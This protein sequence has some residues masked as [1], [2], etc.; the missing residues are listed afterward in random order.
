MVTK[1]AR[2]RARA[3]R[4]MVTATKRARATAARGMARATRVVGNKKRMATATKRAMAT[5]SDNTG[6][7]YEEEGGGHLTAATMAMRLGTARRTRLLALRLER[8]G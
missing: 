4:W 3:A 7:G 2:A 5:D 1:M 6:N 8:G